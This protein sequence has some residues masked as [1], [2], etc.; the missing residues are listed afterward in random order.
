[1]GLPPV[2]F[3]SGAFGTGKTTLAPLVATRLPECFVLDVDW[4]L[5]PLSVLAGQDLRVFEP[6]WPALGDLWLTVAGISA[7]ANRSSVLFSAVYPSEIEHLP[8][9]SLVGESH[10]LLLDCADEIIQARLAEREDWPEAETRASLIDASH[11]RTLGLP[12]LRTDEASPEETAK[13]I[14]AWVRERLPNEA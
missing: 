12:A 9:R 2:F 5:E 7:Q 1:L 13:Q 3:V 6:A 10:W 11:F 14:V 4:L 8:S